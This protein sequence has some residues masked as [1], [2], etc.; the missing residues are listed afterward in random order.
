MNSGPGD[1]LRV[2]AEVVEIEPEFLERCVRE[3]AVCLEELPDEPERLSPS[4][5][6]RLRRLH[7]L[8]RGLEI[9]V[10]AGSIIVDLLDRMD[11]MQGEMERLQ[12]C[13]PARPPSPRI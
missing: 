12:P 4:Q 6:A 5:T 11:I 7:R 8:C 13:A 9:D 1:R 3:G 2:V 10:F